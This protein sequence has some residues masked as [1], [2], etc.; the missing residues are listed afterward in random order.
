MSYIGTTPKDTFTTGLVD[1]FTSTTGT[2][3][4]LTHE[5]SSKNDIIVF[6][7]FVK[8]DSTNYS[9]GGTGNKTL[10]LGGTLVSSDIVEV[11]YLNKVFATQQPSANSVG[12][13]E[14][15]LSEGTSGQALTTNGSGTLSFSTIS[16]YANSDALTLFNASGSAP[17]FACRSWI[18]FNGKSTIAIRDDGNVSSIADNGT[19]DYT[20]TFTTAMEDTNYCILTSSGEDVSGGGANHIGSQ[21]H[22]S[23]PTTTTCRINTVSTTG[24][25]VDHQFIYVAIFR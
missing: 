12:I 14:L 4:T 9:V 21:L 13:T 7:N 20:I 10:T 11:H 19:G 17:V 23:T 24:S 15:N 5:I 3:V 16:S 6:V 25:A 2:T 18:N 1:R 8:Q 22:R